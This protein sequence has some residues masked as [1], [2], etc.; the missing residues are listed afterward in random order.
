MIND[1]KLY[2][3]YILSGIQILFKS[4]FKEGIDSLIVISLFDERFF[5]IKDAHLATIE[6]N[7]AYKKLL[8]TCYPS[9]SISLKDKNFNDALSLHFE[10][11]NKKLLKPGNKVMSIYYSALFSFCNT[12]YGD[13]FS[14]KPFIEIKEECQE[15][16]RIREP[17]LQEIKIP[18][19]Y[20]IGFRN[21]KA[22]EEGSS[23]SN[24]ENIPMEY[25][26]NE[27]IV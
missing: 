9:Y 18:D 26:N 11:L 25:K 8:F 13:I 2:N 17:L 15:V 19:K 27:I 1:S 24:I 5:N 20:R 12:N 7:L 14:N 21:V 10:L 23:S 6:G 16:T 4:L 22:I 3:M